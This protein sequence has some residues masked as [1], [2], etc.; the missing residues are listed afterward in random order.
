MKIRYDIVRNDFLAFGEHFYANSAY[1][2]QV[3]SN[4]RWRTTAG[5]FIVFC[6]F[7]LFWR[8]PIFVALGFLF[9][10]ANF[11]LYPNSYRRSF[12][13]HFTN[14]LDEGSG[15][16][17]LGEHEL[18]LTESGIVERTDFNE[19]NVTWQGIGKIVSTKDHTFIYVGENMAHILPRS[20]ILEGNYES[21]VNALNHKYSHQRS[22]KAVQVS[23][24]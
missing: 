22:S 12:I 2:Y 3:M 21:F 10:A 1:T 5:I 17:I 23:D 8:T 15:K 14:Y 11:H 16:G 19:H 24:N 18:D 20:S 6:I 13:K 9:A 7:E 4:K